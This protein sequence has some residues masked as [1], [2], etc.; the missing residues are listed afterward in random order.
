MKKKI[1]LSLILILS[2]VLISLIACTLT[3]T[4]EFEWEQYEKPEMA[5]WSSTKLEAA[6]DYSE[7]LNSAAVMVVYKG[8]VVIA[9]GD[10]KRNLKCHSIRKALL[11]ALYG[12]HVD[13]GNIDINKTLAELEIDDVTPLTKAEKQ[14]E[15]IHLLRSRSGIYLNALGEGPGMR[16]MRPK[17]G[18]HAPDEYYYYNNW[19]FNALGTIFEKETG[20]KIFEEFK[21]KIAD[22]ISMQDFSLDL[23][24][25]RYEDY[26]LH[27]YYFF[28]MSTRD[29]ARFGL[30]YERYGVWNGQRIISKRWIKESTTS[31]S[32]SGLGGYGYMWKT[33][34]KEESL[35]YGFD[36]LEKYNLY[37]IT[38]IAVHMLAIIPK[39]ELV[40]IHRFDSDSSIPHYESLP[41]YKLLDLIIVAK[42][43]NPQSKLRFTQLKPIPYSGRPREKVPKKIVKVSTEVLDSYAGKYELP[44][45]RYY[46]EREGDHLKILEADRRPF[47]ELLPESESLFFFKNWDRQIEFVRKDSGN[48]THFN[49]IIKGVRQK[50]IR[51]E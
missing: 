44:Y 6:K 49:L 17:R 16:A 37:S 41:V 24:E 21:E 42:V 8:K 1:M 29:L 47:D 43:G 35:K 27:P 46:I 31:Y 50:A 9:W 7:E 15:I 28:R 18:S 30:L 3:K 40:Y 13:S 4:R 5:G 48:V 14:A 23:T 26:T 39:L 38:G 32:D 45:Y 51:T 12:I 20:K 10:L 11:S 19:G 2:A 22:P 25:M 36:S 34:P 33:F